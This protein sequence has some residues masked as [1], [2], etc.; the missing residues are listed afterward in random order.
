ML[1]EIKSK[2]YLNS[3][4]KIVLSHLTIPVLDIFISIEVL[5]VNRILSESIKIHTEIAIPLGR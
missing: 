1:T 5:Y 3:I 4:S 2:D